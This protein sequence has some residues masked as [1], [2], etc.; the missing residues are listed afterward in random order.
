MAVCGLPTERADHAVVMA[1]FAR[2]C[3]LQMHDQLEFLETSLGPDTASL[4]M[5]VGLHSGS[6]TA[7][8]YRERGVRSVC[9]VF[10]RPD[11][12][13]ECSN[14]EVI[15]LTLANVMNRCPTRRQGTIPTV[16]TPR[17]KRRAFS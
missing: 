16:S 9:T 14:T 2:E 4:G 17:V 12:E 5:R 13:R 1:R 6:V 11:V 10:S 7:G 15:V 8:K 3:L